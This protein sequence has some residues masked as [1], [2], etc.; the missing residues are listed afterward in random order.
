[1]AHHHLEKVAMA[2]MYHRPEM[3]HPAMELA[4]LEQSISVRAPQ[5]LAAQVQA[6]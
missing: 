5:E 3:M 1:V 2:R 4:G 6:V